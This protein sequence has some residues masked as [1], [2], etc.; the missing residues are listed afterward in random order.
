MTK[1]ISAV[2]AAMELAELGRS[3]GLKVDID[4]QA[5]TFQRGAIMSQ[6]ERYRYAIWQTWSLDPMMAMGLLNP[7]TASHLIDDPTWDRGRKRAGRSQSPRFGGVMYW[8]AFAFRATDPDVMMAAADPVGEHNDAF[9]DA[10]LTRSA[11]TIIGYGAKGAHRGRADEVKARIRALQVPVHY[12][13]LTK[14]G[15]PGHPLYLPEA[16][17]PTLWEFD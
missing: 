13:R 4:E 5:P 1:M 8:N 17:E 2:Q 9:I 7:S 6:D 16:L 10:A 15:H 14:H 12:L 11:M 3:L